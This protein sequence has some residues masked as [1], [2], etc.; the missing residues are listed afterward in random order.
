M[1]NIIVL[2]I[3]YDGCFAGKALQN[4]TENEEITLELHREIID[5]LAQ[6]ICNKGYSE[7]V[8]LI[9][10]NR[11][12]V[13]S[14][15][16]N[17]VL[18]G[19]GSC[20][21]AISI[22]AQELE[23]RSGVKTRF[24]PV[25]MADVYN[26]TIDG[27]SL[28]KGIADAEKLRSAR[29]TDLLL[30]L[31]PNV[32][33]SINK[34]RLLKRR[35]IAAL[36]FEKRHHQPFDYENG[37]FDELEKISLETQLTAE[38]EDKFARQASYDVYNILAKL[39]LNHDGW[40]FDDSKLS[41]VYMQMQK[42]ALE[43][44]NDKITFRLYDDTETILKNLCLFFNEH[45]E[46]IP[47]NNTL[48]L[49]QYEGPNTV[50]DF[51]KTIIKGQGIPNSYF[52]R[53]IK[54]IGELIASQT[55]ATDEIKRQ[56]YQTSGNFLADKNFLSPLLR[57]GLNQSEGA[58]KSYHKPDFQANDKSKVQFNLFK[59]SLP[60][61]AHQ[62]SVSDEDKQLTNIVKKMKENVDQYSQDFSLPH[63]DL[64]G[65][66]PIQWACRKAN[67]D[68]LKEHVNDPVN[69]LR[70]NGKKPLH[71]LASYGNLKGVET[72]L[73]HGAVT[74]ADKAGMYPV[75]L[76]LCLP[77]IEQKNDLIEENIS[78]RT[79][80]YRML[81][82]AAPES[83]AQVNEEGFGVAHYMAMYGFSELLEEL[84][85]NNSPLLLL[86]EIHEEIPAHLAIRNG[87]IACLII[88][89]QDEKVKN[90]SSANQ[91][92]LL[93]YAAT[94]GSEEAVRACMAAGIPYQKDPQE[95]TPAMRAILANNV[96]ALSG[97][98]IEELK[99][100]K[101]DSNNGTLLDYALEHDASSCIEW[102]SRHTDLAQ[103]VNET[104]H[105]RITM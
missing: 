67:L 83:V 19:N 25:L 96:N 32:L 41:V 85:E 61:V 13:Q 48:E 17:A 103:A 21:T 104:E 59:P 90:F 18:Y 80:V 97:F 54:A 86:T 77:M 74:C 79:Q 16:K 73:H 42:K 44:L 70:D 14:D 26:D 46:S 22:I 98:N 47:Q 28:Q 30:K 81:K 4:V 49:C 87:K 15:S 9:G 58:E 100:E 2:S 62:T 57:A 31:P 60:I 99:Q 64:G 84:V 69:S 24:D 20:F 50:N 88:L 68:F 23:K 6:E 36:E 105:A 55:L 66:T 78:K 35:E 29:S 101:I 34:A 45:P 43:Y 37:D 93:H 8:V 27:F 5:E 92:N 7:C 72:M 52:K 38:E 82:A 53:D 33:S 40:V 76:A 56:N 11:Q 51:H 10:S 95:R 71:L 91:G 75:H 65:F 63:A 102:L 89:L 39:E 3:D 12:S 94:Y 1:K